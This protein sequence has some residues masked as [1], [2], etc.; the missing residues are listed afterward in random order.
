MSVMGDLGTTSGE[1]VYMEGGRR[2]SD[3]GNKSECEEAE[4][5]CRSHGETSV[6]SIQ[7]R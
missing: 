4:Q 1:S 6:V 7:E 5:L 2:K 3:D